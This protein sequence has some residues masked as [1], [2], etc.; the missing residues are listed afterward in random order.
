LN[1]IRAP[2]MTRAEFLD[3]RRTS[4]RYRNDCLL[5]V[6]DLLGQLLPG[7][8]LLLLLPQSTTFGGPLADAVSLCAC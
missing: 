3:E 7:Q 8:L 6:V 1:V 5:V 2:S 4:L